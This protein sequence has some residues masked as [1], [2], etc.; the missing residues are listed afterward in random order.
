MTTAFIALGANLGDRQAN[1]QNAIRLLDD[2]EGIAVTAVSE[3]VESDP[4][5]QMDQPAYL[6]AVVQVET[7]LG[8]DELF[9]RMTSI[10]ETL[11]R[12]RGE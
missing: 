12:V 3:V 2:T 5:A 7:D 10:E 9:G 11:G 4:L 8:A 1:I 6:D